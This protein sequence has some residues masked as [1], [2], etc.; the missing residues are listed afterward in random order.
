MKNYELFEKVIKNFGELDQNLKCG[1]LF[2]NTE[3]KKIYSYNEAI[4]KIVNGE[5]FVYGKT[6]QFNNFLS[7]TTSKHINLLIRT[8]E[9]E[10]FNFKVIQE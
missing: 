10:Q 7:F 1:K 2:F 8:L 4:L 9:Q 6:K 5:F 3:E